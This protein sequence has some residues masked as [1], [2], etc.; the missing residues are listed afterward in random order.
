[1]VEGGGR[2]LRSSLLSLRKIEKGEKRR[3]ETCLP[4]AG[5]DKACFQKSKD[6]FQEKSKCSMVQP[7]FGRK[8]IYLIQP[9]QN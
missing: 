3:P 1:M 2:I 4:F 5:K 6:A 9:R 8:Q 7:Q